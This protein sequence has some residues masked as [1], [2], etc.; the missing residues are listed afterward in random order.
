MKH[1]VPVLLLVACNGGGFPDAP[2]EKP[3]PGDPGGFSVSWSITDAGGQ[4]ATCAQ[5]KATSVSVGITDAVSM[6]RASVTFDCGLGA[7]FSGALASS[8][9]NVSFTLVDAQGTLATATTQT[10]VVVTANHTTQ[11]APVTFSLATPAV[12]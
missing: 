7:A 9:Y 2:S 12:R 6:A 3:A 11:L 4:P 10:G 5:A 8:T 1:V